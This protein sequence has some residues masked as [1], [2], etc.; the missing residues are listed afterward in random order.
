MTP[1]MIKLAREIDDAFPGEAYRDPDSV[2]VYKHEWESAQKLATAILAHRSDFSPDGEPL[3]LRTDESW[4]DEF[5]FTRL[6]DSTTVAQKIIGDGRVALYVE[7]RQR[8]TLICLDGNPL[9]HITTRHQ[10]RQLL[11]SL[12]GGAA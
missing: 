2:S 8:G 10:L 3:D 1:E 6:A 11:A 12:G 9:K 7:V 5:R 4:I